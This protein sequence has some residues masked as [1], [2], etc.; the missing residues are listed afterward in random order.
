MLLRDGKLFNA[1]PG[2]IIHVQLYGIE[3][4]GQSE[5]ERADKSVCPAN[6][7]SPRSIIVM[8]IYLHK[9]EVKQS[10]RNT[11]LMVVKN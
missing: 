6:S 8:Y 2:T 10:V 4:F 5:E 1:S 7:I 11:Q 3:E 9:N